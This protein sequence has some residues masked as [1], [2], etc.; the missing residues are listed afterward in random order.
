ME[1]RNE[2]VDLRLNVYLP[3]DDETTPANVMGAAP[4][5]PPDVMV[6]DIVIV[7]HEIGIVTG[8][9]AGTGDVFRA[10]KQPLPGVDAEIGYR[11]PVPG[12]DFRIFLGA[13]HFEGGNDYENV[14]GPKAR[15]EWR[16]HDL[17]LFGNNS[18]LTL[19][20]GIR[21]DDVRGTDAS[22]GLRIR[23]PFG[24]VPSNQRGHEL[25]GLDQRMLDPIRRED[26]IVMGDR[27]EEQV[28][29]PGGVTIDA[30]MAIET[31]NE[32]TSIWFAD[33]AGG[34]DGTMGNETDLATA[35]SDPG[36]GDQ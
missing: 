10:F 32:I 22:A 31:G 8:S 12:H 24:G 9:T 16:L 27:E 14:T 7:D 29:S 25:A 33:G 2:S 5:L 21:D 19:E 28:G 6:G 30:V 4:P 20:A 13:F 11:L 26:H 35:V 15:A 18:R 36:A 23:I 34:G 17:D 1:A 3:E